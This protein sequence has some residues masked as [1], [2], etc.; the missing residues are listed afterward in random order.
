LP[1]VRIQSCHR[2]K[3]NRGRVKGGAKKIPRND[4]GQGDTRQ[5]KV[6]IFKKMVWVGQ[7]CQARGNRGRKVRGDRSGE[8][9]LSTGKKTCELANGG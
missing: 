3:G 5:R 2:P 6:S 8:G 1:N 4:Y 7:Q 9:N